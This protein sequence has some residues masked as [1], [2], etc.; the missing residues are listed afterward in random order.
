MVKPPMF[1]GSTKIFVN[2]NIE[3]IHEQWQLFSHNTGLKKTKEVVE[4]FGVSSGTTDQKETKA[5]LWG[6]IGTHR[7]VLRWRESEQYRA[8]PQ[9]EGTGR[10]LHRFLRPDPGHRPAQRR[11]RTRR[12]AL[13]LAHRGTPHGQ[14]PTALTQGADRRAP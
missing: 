6:A 5:D 1:T 2:N 12:G 7:H 11:V 4:K 13:R 10:D 9:P 14:A 8:L 3:S